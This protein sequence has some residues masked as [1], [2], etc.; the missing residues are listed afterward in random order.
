MPDKSTRIF[1]IDDD[2]SVRTSLARLLGA[3]G[4][5]TE[6]F[7]SAEEYLARER[8]DGVACLILDVRMPGSSGLELQDTLN[9]L[10]SDLPILFLTGHGDI[11]MSVKAIRGG[12]VNFLTKPVSEAVLLSA[13][14]QALA[15][16]KNDIKNN[17]M[18]NDARASLALL[19]SREQEIMR[20][21]L[22]GARNRQ[23]ASHLGIT[24]KTVKAHRAKIMTKMGV[25]SA[26]ELGRVCAQLAITP[27]TIAAE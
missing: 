23:I 8:F 17:D 16:Y 1:I 12:A 3:A 13:V 2:R 14:G 26:V 7:A 6:V 9:E 20:Y 11:P 25:S 19:T 4:F 10:G 15:E 27:K 24:E 21:I 18:N 22:S 5:A